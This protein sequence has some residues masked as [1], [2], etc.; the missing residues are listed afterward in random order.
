M[1]IRNRIICI[2][3][4][5]LVV[6][7]GIP[8]QAFAG[9]STGGSGS[10]TEGGTG[11][12]HNALFRVGYYFV[13]PKPEDET[14]AI[15]SL[16]NLVMGQTG[17]SQLNLDG[18]ADSPNSSNVFFLCDSHTTVNPRIK[19]LA[20]CTA[21]QQR[22]NRYADYGWY[23]LN[24]ENLS[25]SSYKSW[26]QTIAAASSQ[27]SLSGS[28][29]NPDTPC[30]AMKDL[31]GADYTNYGEV[32]NGDKIYEYLCTKLIDGN[33][34][35]YQQ[36]EKDIVAMWYLPYTGAGLATTP[37]SAKCT[38]WLKNIWVYRL[39][40]SGQN[41]NGKAITNDIQ[42]K[43]LQDLMV[44][45]MAI[46]IDK[47]HQKVY[48][49]KSNLDLK[50][51]L[52]QWCTN[53]GNSNMQ[54]HNG[55]LMIKA[56]VWAYKLGAGNSHSVIAADRYDYAIAMVH[57]GLNVKDISEPNWNVDGNTQSPSERNYEM[58][59]YDLNTA[60]NEFYN[61][62]VRGIVARASNENRKIAYNSKLADDAASHVSIFQGVAI[63]D[64]TPWTG[65][66]KN[67]SWN[68]RKMLYTTYWTKDASGNNKYY[69]NIQAGWTMIYP[70][71]PNP[72]PTPNNDWGLHHDVEVYS[73]NTN[74]AKGAKGSCNVKINLTFPQIPDQADVNKYKLNVSSF[75]GPEIDKLNM[76][77][78]INRASNP[79][80]VE[81]GDPNIPVTIT[82]NRS[83][84]S[85]DSKMY[86]SPNAGE[87]P[88]YTCGKHSFTCVSDNGKTAV[89]KFNLVPSGK[90]CGNVVY[91]LQNDR[92]KLA[93]GA[94]DVHT[95]IH[96]CALC[97]SLIDGKLT[98]SF[99][100]DNIDVPDTKDTQVPVTYTVTAKY[101][102]PKFKAYEQAY[103]TVDP[104]RNLGTVET[105]GYSVLPEDGAYPKSDWVKSGAEYKP[106]LQ[107]QRTVDLLTDRENPSYTNKGIESARLPY[108][109]I[110]QGNPK[111]EKYEA[112]AGTPT[113][114]DLY[115][116]CSGNEFYVDF[117][118]Q[119]KAVVN[120]QAYRTITYKL[121]CPSCTRGGT[122]DCPGNS[123]GTH[124]CCGND[125]RGYDVQTENGSYHKVVHCYCPN[126]ECTPSHPGSHSFTLKVH[127][128]IEACEYFDMTKYEVWRMTNFQT[129]GG[130][131]KVGLNVSKDLPTHFY[132]L[133]VGNY[134]SGNGRY[135]FTKNP[136]GA[137]GALQ[138]GDCVVDLGTV[139]DTDHETMA[140]NVKNKFQEA[141]NAIP[142]FQAICLSDFMV[143]ETSNGIQTPYYYSYKT[144]A[145]NASCLAGKSPTISIGIN[146][147]ISNEITASQTLKWEEHPTFDDLWTNNAR[148]QCAS[149]AHG[150]DTETICYDGYNGKYSTPSEKY[151]NSHPG[152]FYMGSKNLLK[153]DLAK[154]G[155]STW[156]PPNASGKAWNSGGTGAG[157]KILDHNI[158]LTPDRTAA[159][160]EYYTGKVQATWVREALSG[161][162]IFYP[163][164]ASYTNT[165]VKYYDGADKVNDIVFHNPVSA[166]N[167]MVVTNDAQYDKR[168]NAKL[169]QGGDP[170]NMGSEVCPAYGCQYSTLKCTTPITEHT[171][172]CYSWVETV[173]KTHVG[174]LNAH[175]HT[176]DCYETVST[177][178]NSITA[179][180][181][182]QHVKQ[183]RN[184]SITVKPGD[185]VIVGHNNAFSGTCSGGS[186]TSIYTT[187]SGAKYGI[188]AAV[189]A[190]LVSD[191]QRYC[192]YYGNGNFTK[193]SSR[194]AKFNFM[195]NEC[196][197]YSYI[198]QPSNNDAWFLF[199]AEQ[200][201]IVQIEADQEGTSNDY[202]EIRVYDGSQFGRRCICESA[203]TYIA[204]VN[205]T[206]V[207]YS[208]W[209]DLQPGD[210]FTGSYRTCNGTNGCCLQDES[211][212]VVGQAGQTTTITKSGK[213]RVYGWAHC[214]NQGY[215]IKRTGPVL[216]KHV[217]T[218]ACK[219]SK[220]EKV[221][222]C[223][224]P[225]HVNPGE[226]TD[227]NDPAHHYPLG[228]PRCWQRCGN[229]ANHRM[230]QEVK[231]D[232]G[233][234]IKMG[235]TFINLD[236][237]F[238][239]YFPYTGDFAEKPGLY[240]IAE[241]TAT[242]GKG[243]ANGMNTKT[244][245]AARFVTFPFNVIDP[246]GKL[247]TAGEHI[248][249]NDFS[250][251]DLYFTFYCVLNNVEAHHADVVFSATANNGPGAT[252]EGYWDESVD[253]TNKDR[254]DPT[255]AAR[256]TASKDHY[257]DVVG[258]IGALTIHDTGDFRFANL[259]K[260]SRG[261]GS[262]LIDNLVPNVYENIP[263]KVVAD[264]TTSRLDVMAKPWWLST[265]GMTKS[266]TGGKGGNT[267]GENQPLTL[268]LAPW[269]NPIEALRNQPM[270]P[271]YQLYMD[272][273]TV[274]NYYGTTLNDDCT[275]Y[276]DANMLQKAQI[277]PRYYSLDLK[278]HKYTPVD[279]Y[280][281][282]DNEYMLVN[283]WTYE[284][285]DDKVG[286]KDFYYYLDWGNEASRRSYTQNEREAT[287]R[288]WTSLDSADL[289][290]RIP[291]TAKDVI[292]SANILFLNDLNR[293]FIGS[294]K[295]YGQDKNPGS[296]LS[297]TGYN[298]QS[299]RWHFTLGLPSSTV[300]V[301]KGKPCTE[302]NIKTLQSKHRVIVCTLNIKVRG[303]IW[304]M[305]YDGH[306]NNNDG[307]KVL[308]NGDTYQPPMFDENGKET[309]DPTKDVTSGDIV[310]VVYP[311]DKTSKDDVTIS[312]TH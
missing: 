295:T 298:Q 42:G 196:P 210:I 287:N 111:S 178:W 304:T 198:N 266:P 200:Q 312:G 310:V 291:S 73:V 195:Y 153:E 137:T 268:P 3:T 70:M 57:D 220:K 249:L 47:Q 294:S 45:C 128:P 139:P 61:Y 142:A 58:K 118:G 146:S 284:P 190:G 132:G 104:M 30:T 12:Y 133:D 253:T 305:D 257:I 40:G 72:G 81:S 218:S 303:S 66:T 293:T 87:M 107:V 167:A 152:E 65:I 169:M 234:V 29:W 138:Y 99:R 175:E 185:Y 201:I 260:M 64:S 276:V 281:G 238:K 95:D 75:K 60:P 160:G 151:N 114:E 300:F 109:E 82:V 179:K 172:A 166:E 223:T 32:W 149:Q 127:I 145:F 19:L 23:G 221:L 246:A 244:W 269:M 194:N 103:G 129:V 98:I 46:V 116:N 71:G 232:A 171:D 148:N 242:R 278:T 50:T 54:A 164:K 147:N 31:C 216:N 240:G 134:V 273:E 79:S 290:Y 8:I 9:G 285:K 181:P 48:G 27:T 248:N 193:I 74:V 239:I 254:I 96:N 280:Y 182:N 283:Q 263:N 97:Q 34:P 189:N 90:S 10:M 297:E 15:F 250:K 7:A 199:K 247:R 307:F 125:C 4:A 16:K 131:S 44:A 106:S 141:L 296:V 156:A 1:N 86:D 119:N 121:A 120:P 77:E 206:F 212:A 251:D 26:A 174:G 159:N 233:N 176:D 267:N 11:S 92:E 202:T 261:D 192:Y 219:A 33:G 130:D 105:T 150:W 286:V 256:H 162:Q 231:D 255:Y 302:A 28:F 279:V 13:T 143:F 258:Y 51:W 55:H 311:S 80:N 22:I 203:V 94:S 122:V 157:G 83:V 274:G 115:L 224:D 89:F 5:L 18:A 17:E 37:N 84:T 205:S 136:N 243:Y 306:L 113:T 308:E 252:D 158:K 277:R 270:R 14:G 228:D 110:K 85:S 35:E 49:T 186:S 117:I 91:T 41:Y 68:Y 230:H 67:G 56:D 123:C 197:T 275:A 209:Y 211:G 222:T 135:L 173:A 102:F 63:K 6:L 237:E 301:E 163:G 208:Q 108:A 236:R 241:T 299:Q 183:S 155:L 25:Y 38:E 259:F 39:S 229:D 140:T 272:F 144:D 282:V 292:G 264:K 180:T 309:L 59:G 69:K 154:C 177:D 204:Q 265:Y 184:L 53:G 235:G 262:W 124:G 21:T 225:H 52:K 24:F 165:N 227:P 93:R 214:S 187:G 288:V 217:C 271:G 161:K 207:G 20:D 215:N 191:F 245:T 76:A 101:D 126:I 289:H 213:Y 226:S 100:D 78:I 43:R 170:P 88:I 36:L 2:C 62:W 168:T 112:M 188:E